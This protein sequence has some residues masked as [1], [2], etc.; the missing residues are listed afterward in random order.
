M[1]NKTIRKSLAIASGLALASAALVAAPANAAITKLELSPALGTGTQTV[2]GATFNLKLLHV[3]GTT[4]AVEYYVTGATAANITAKDGAGITS[5]TAIPTISND[6]TETAVSNAA[7]TANINGAAV[8]TGKY[9]VLSISLD[10]TEI[11]TTTTITVTPFIDSVI[12]NNTIDADEV[13]GNTLSI[14]FNAASGV[15]ATS[16]VTAPALGTKAVSAV[17][18]LDSSI[19][20]VDTVGALSQVVFKKNGADAKTDSSAP[21]SIADGGY[22]VSGTFTANAADGDVVSAQAFMIGD[23]SVGEAVALSTDLVAGTVAT[24]TDVTE[25]KGTSFLASA[26]AGGVTTADALRAGSG[27]FE[28]V[29]T[30]DSTTAG[31]VAGI[32][33]VFEIDETS[34][35]SFGGAT[36]TAGGK[37]LTDATVSAVDKIEVTVLT[38]ATGAATLPISYSSLDNTETFDV[39]AT[40]AGATAVKGGTDVKYTAVNSFATVVVSDVDGGNATAATFQVVKGSTASLNY[41]VRDQFGQVPTGTFRAKATI[42]GAAADV[43][44][45]FAFSSGTGTLTWTDASD[46][47]DATSAISALTLEKLNTAGTAYADVTTDTAASVDVDIIAAATTPSRVT[48]TNSVSAGTAKTILKKDYVVGDERWEQT[49]K[50]FLADGDVTSNITG[51]VYSATGGAVAGA[52]VT[53]TAPGVLLT[54]H[55]ETV[56]SL[57]SITV[58]TNPSGAYS[59]GYASNTVGTKTFTVTSGSGSA[60][61]STVFNGVAETEVA[62]ITIS[63]PASAKPGSTVTAIAT[64]TDQFGNPVAVDDSTDSEPQVAF[65]YSGPGLVV[66]T[67]PVASDANGQM[68]ISVLLGSNDSGVGTFTATHDADNDGLLTEPDVN[69]L[70]VTAT[71]TVSEDAGVVKKVNAGSFKGY[72]AVY[73]R[74]Y[75]GQRLS[76]KIGKDW[77]IVDPIVNNQEDGTLFRVTDFTGA[78]V[79][80]AVRIY[81]DRVLIDTINLTT[82]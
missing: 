68:K 34:D 54:N 56:Y 52:Q 24:F 27:T 3:G 44:K 50:A 30:V 19:N 65:T 76:A 80:I 21:Y 75:E 13:K 55:A 45:T 63:V 49:S 12:A 37:S 2:L 9:D 74:G 70:A 67:T 79:D 6:I 64:V 77:V 57:G 72:V 51:V 8:E 4:D 33:V 58:E 32:P 39:S 59:V 47:A 20:M 15:N 10:A 66:G 28:V 26:V 43:N 78:G 48:A 46:A 1:A 23:T 38:D 62:A 31:S 82:K 14:T 22:E 7:L 81:I 60:T 61:T 73:A 41:Y 5:L 16:V 53:I 69:N 17:V 42:T 36:I 40:A 35:A 18:T 25:N 29:Y 11:T 71:V